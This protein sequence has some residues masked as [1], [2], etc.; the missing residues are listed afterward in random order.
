MGAARAEKG[1]RGGAHAAGAR[2]IPLPVGQRTVGRR[3]SPGEIRQWNGAREIRCSE[4]EK[5]ILRLD[6]RA[7]TR[8]NAAKE[9]KA[10]L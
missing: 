2:Q 1:K 6:A 10:P 3:N 4:G 9:G 7:A 5:R 8:Y